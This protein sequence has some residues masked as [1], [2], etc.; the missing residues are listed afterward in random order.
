MELKVTVATGASLE[1]QKPFIIFEHAGPTIPIW[2]A[3]RTTQ[4][5]FA[6]WK[7]KCSSLLLL[8]IVSTANRR[9]FN[10]TLQREALA[11]SR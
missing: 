9:F 3:P 1:A 7:K 2:I 4:C 8:A 11:V 10:W 5:P 6:T